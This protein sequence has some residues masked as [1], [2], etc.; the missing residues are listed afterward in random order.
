MVHTTFTPT[1]TFTNAGSDSTGAGAA[2]YAI[3]GGEKLNGNGGASY[4][5][6]RIEYQTIVRS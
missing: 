2:A 5:I 4:R 6:K 3:L 1:I